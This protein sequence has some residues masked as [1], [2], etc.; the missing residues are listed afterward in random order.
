MIDTT[1]DL[2][3]VIVIATVCLLAVIFLV[4]IGLIAVRKQEKPDRRIDL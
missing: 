4:I 3:L 2:I 1:S